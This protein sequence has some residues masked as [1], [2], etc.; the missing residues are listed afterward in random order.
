MMISI[1]KITVKMSFCSDWGI[2]M[3]NI[4]MKL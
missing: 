2:I 4:C 1:G 3:M